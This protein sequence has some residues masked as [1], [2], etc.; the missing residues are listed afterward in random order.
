MVF[1]N[2]CQ[3]AHYWANGIEF[4]ILL[5]PS[6]WKM[7]R[8]TYYWLIWEG[9]IG[10]GE[11]KILFF[12]R[13]A[14][15]SYWVASWI[16]RFIILYYHFFIIFVLIIS[17]FSY[18]ENPTS[19]SGSENITF[20][21]CPDQVSTKGSA[22]SH[23]VSEFSAKEGLNSC[24]KQCQIK[25]KRHSRQAFTIIFGICSKKPALNTKSFYLDIAKSQSSDESTPLSRI[26]IYSKGQSTRVFLSQN[27][28]VMIWL[29]I[30]KR[31]NMWRYARHLNSLSR[32]LHH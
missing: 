3:P 17:V 16:L 31:R 25:N 7:G 6:Q 9:I 27:L 21:E 30:F 19:M 29:M 24:F 32:L 10:S 1:A 28:I 2:G 5:D 23:I 11:K 14:L 18:F 13:R 20:A 26:G 4:I 8:L 15:S 12:H 22:I